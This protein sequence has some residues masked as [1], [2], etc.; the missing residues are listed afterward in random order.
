MKLRTLIIF[1]LITQVSLSQKLYTSPITQ[2][3]PSA[4]LEI[5]NRT[6][7]FTKDTV[8]MKSETPYGL[9]IK[10]YVVNQYSVHTFP[11]NGLSD[12]FV[13]SSLDNI[14]ITYFQIPIRDKVEFIEVVE[15]LQFYRSENRYRLLLD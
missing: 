7:L 1:Y 6:I 10:K 13:C 11:V 3:F 8:F 2:Y 9:Q 5:I 15:P 4:D 14:Y 12:F